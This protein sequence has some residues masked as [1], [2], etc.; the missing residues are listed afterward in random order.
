SATARS[1]SRPSRRPSGSARAR[2]A[3]TPSSC[4]ERAPGRRPG[5][6]ACLRQPW[7]QSN[8]VSSFEEGE[9]HMADKPKTAADVLKLVKENDVKLL[10]LRFTDTKGKIQHVTG[11]ASCVDEAMFADGHAFDGSSIAGWKGIEASDMTLML[12]PASAHM[13]PFFAQTTMAIFCDVIE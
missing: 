7:R 6:S 5:A 13:D 2:R 10:A 4:H 3:Q 1:S 8:E 12:D 9:A 11:D